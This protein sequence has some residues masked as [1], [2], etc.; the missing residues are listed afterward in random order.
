M[1]AN[2]ETYSWDNI[3]KVYRRFAE[4]PRSV[5]YSTDDGFT[6]QSP[7]MDTGKWGSGLDPKVYRNMKFAFLELLPA[8]E[9]K[10]FTKLW[11]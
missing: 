6:W 11:T 7:E 4:N 2:V 5:V 3:Q 10:D 8:K 1:K 9:I